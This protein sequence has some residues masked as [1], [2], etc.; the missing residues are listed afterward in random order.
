[1]KGTNVNAYLKFPL[2]VHFSLDRSHRKKK[3]EKKKVHL[4]EY[5]SKKRQKSIHLH[6]MQQTNAT[7]V[8]T[9]VS[10][11][12]STSFDSWEDQGW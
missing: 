5:A 2:L 8:T 10:T 6:S 12:G 4:Y 7:Y 9:Q 1:M 11:I 3:N